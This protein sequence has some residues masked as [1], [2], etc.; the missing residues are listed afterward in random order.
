MSKA[1]KCLDIDGV[2]LTAKE[3]S[4]CIKYLQHLNRSKAVIDAGYCTKGKKP[5]VIAYE[6]LKRDRIRKYLS[7][8]LKAGLIVE[9]ASAIADAILTSDLG[10]IYVDSGNSFDIKDIYNA[11]LSH[12]IRSYKRKKITRTDKDGN[13]TQ[14]IEIEIERE[15]KLR[16]ADVLAKLQG[17]YNKNVTN[18]FNH[19][20]CR[21]K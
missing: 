21:K 8:Q 13:I 12:L 15:D 4:F 10:K 19:N 18:S 7:I 2:Q 16:A 3:F 11:G 20:F 17:W 9:K 1:A 6:L 5:R 14:T